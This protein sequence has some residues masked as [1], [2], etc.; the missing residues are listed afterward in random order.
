VPSIST[1]SEKLRKVLMSTISPGHRRFQR[2]FHG[3]DESYLTM[4]Y[5]DA[6]PGS[7]EGR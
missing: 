5:V 1:S 3:L 2:G 6:D 7:D 4:S